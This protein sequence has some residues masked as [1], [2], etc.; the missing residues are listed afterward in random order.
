MSDKNDIVLI[1]VASARHG[2][3][4]TASVVSGAFQKVDPTAIALFATYLIEEDVPGSS[5]SYVGPMSDGR[6]AFMVRMED[7]SKDPETV[8]K[9]MARWLEDRYDQLTEDAI[10]R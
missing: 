3:S 6:P 4:V 7:E 8:L 1:R 9:G 2:L 10:V 5:V